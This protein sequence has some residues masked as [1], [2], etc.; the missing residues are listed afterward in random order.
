MTKQ[1]WEQWVAERAK[2]YVTQTKAEL[3]LDGLYGV[4]ELEGMVRDARKLSSAMNAEHEKMLNLWF[5]D[6]PFPLDEPEVLRPSD[7]P[8]VELGTSWPQTLAQFAECL[9]AY[10]RPED[11]ARYALA[12]FREMLRRNRFRPDTVTAEIRNHVDG[13]K[14]GI[15]NQLDALE[16]AQ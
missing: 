11:Q 13:G 16:A 4:D 8:D 1:Q 15:F 5:A 10:T 9:A 12:F 2:S 6:C 14:Y 7:K 3:R